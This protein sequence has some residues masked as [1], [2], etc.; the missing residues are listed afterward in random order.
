MPLSVGRAA[1][2]NGIRSSVVRIYTTRSLWRQDDTLNHVVCV[3]VLQL[4]SLLIDGDL[5]GISCREEGK[6]D[7]ECHIPEMAVA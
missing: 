4:G 7:K 1:T 3:C 2:P 6:G 5:P